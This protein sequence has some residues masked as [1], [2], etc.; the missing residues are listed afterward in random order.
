[1]TGE[2]RIPEIQ[3]IPQEGLAILNHT[4]AWCWDKCGICKGGGVDFCGFTVRRKSL[5]FWLG[6][7]QDLLLADPHGRLPL[8]LWEEKRLFPVSWDTF[9]TFRSKTPRQVWEK[10]GESAQE[11]E[12]GMEA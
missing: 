2:Q 12:L 1:M 10:A 9:H 6:W 7:L 11:V 4:L 5:E 8:C 3:I